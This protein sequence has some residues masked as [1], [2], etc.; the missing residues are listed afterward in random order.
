[1]TTRRY[2]GVVMGLLRTATDQRIAELDAPDVALVAGARMAADLLDDPD[3]ATA[4][5]LKEWRA[6]MSDLVKASAAGPLS[7]DD[8]DS[9]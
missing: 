6:I 8:V 1:M 3:L 9:L 5:L 4:A 2:A 7:L